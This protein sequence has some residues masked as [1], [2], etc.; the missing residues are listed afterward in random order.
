ML[1]SV[2][3]AL[4]SL[5]SSETRE[6]FDAY[7]LG[8]SVSKAKS[9]CGRCVRVA[10]LGDA[11]VPLLLSQLNRGGKPVLPPVFCGDCFLNDLTRARHRGRHLFL[12]SARQGRRGGVSG[13]C[14]QRNL[15]NTA[16]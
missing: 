2:M 1:Q 3:R 9:L 11:L 14:K 10:L 7:N 16:Q 13:E 8:R 6:V 12:G 5:T 4:C 15:E